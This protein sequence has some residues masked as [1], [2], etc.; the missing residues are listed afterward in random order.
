MSSFATLAFGGR[1]K[2]RGWGAGLQGAGLPAFSLE[3]AWVARDSKGSSGCQPVTHRLTLVSKR[4]ALLVKNINAKKVL[5]I[6][7]DANTVGALML[8]G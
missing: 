5:T 7:F 2:G 6:R 1:I 3:P 8:I 4:K